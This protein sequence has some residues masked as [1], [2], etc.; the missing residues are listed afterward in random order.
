[1]DATKNCGVFTYLAGLASWETSGCRLSR[2][3]IPVGRQSR[4]VESERTLRHQHP[5]RRFIHHQAATRLH[6]CSLH[7]KATKSA[8]GNGRRGHTTV[9][10]RA[11]ASPVS[12]F[13]GLPDDC[14]PFCL[15]PLTRPMQRTGIM[16]VRHEQLPGPD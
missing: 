5:S 9:T 15:G 13:A 3:L 2:A 6:G 7:A 11:D 1:M 14:T 4:H 16:D 12:T 8:C 10:L